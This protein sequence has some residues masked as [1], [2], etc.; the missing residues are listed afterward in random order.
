MWLVLSALFGI[1]LGFTLTWAYAAR[2]AHR[3]MKGI[4]PTRRIPIALLASRVSS[5]GLGVFVAVGSNLAI[6]AHEPTVLNEIVYFVCVIA[7]TIGGWKWISN[8]KLRAEVP[9]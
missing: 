8:A 4:D 2:E 3:K 9:R 5:I 7:S 6:L 1:G